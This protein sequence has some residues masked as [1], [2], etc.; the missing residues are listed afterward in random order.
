MMETMT[1]SGYNM[2]NFVTID[3]FIP[4]SK[5][6][7]ELLR[8]NPSFTIECQTAYPHCYNYDV[9]REWFLKE[10]KKFKPD[11]YYVFIAQ[12]EL[13]PEWEDVL[14]EFD[15]RKY[16]IW[17]SR[18]LAQNYNYPEDGPRLKGYVLHGFNKE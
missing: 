15:L 6:K 16:V 13:I 3:N 10:I 17:S 14:D 18:D 12:L 4:I 2:I 1:T 8:H 9:T 7:L 5:E 11:E